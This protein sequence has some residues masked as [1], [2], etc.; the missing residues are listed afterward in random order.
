ME[1]DFGAVALSLLEVADL[2]C[3]WCLPGAARLVA[4]SQFSREV[5][6]EFRIVPV[7][8]EQLLDTLSTHHGILPCDK[9]IYEYENTITSMVM[10]S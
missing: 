9:G 5:R 2:D 7:M 3:G 1:L 8:E 6:H 10:R 4:L